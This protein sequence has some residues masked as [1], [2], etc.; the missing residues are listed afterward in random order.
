MSFAKLGL[1]AELLAE[2]HRQ[3]YSKPTP[4]QYQV[5]PAILKGQDILATAETGTGKTASFCLPIIQLLSATTINHPRL[6]RGLILVPTRELALQIQNDLQPYILSIGI[7]SAVIIGGMNIHAQLKKLHRG[8]DI[9]IATPGRLLELISTAMIELSALK[10]VVIDEA[11]RLLDLGFTPSVN[12][13]IQQLPNQRQTLLFSATFPKSIQLLAE[14]I[15]QNPL[16]IRLNENHKIATQ[17]EQLVYPIKAEY[18]HELLAYW[19]QHYRWSQVLVFVRTK[20]IAERLMKQLIAQGIRSATLHSDKN[21]TERVTVLNWFIAGRITALIATDIAARGLDIEQLAQVVN[22]DLPIIAEDYIHR[23]GRTGRAGYSG[24]AW[25]LV[26]PEQIEQLI[27]IEKLLK[28]QIP[29][30]VNTGYESVSLTP[31]IK[32]KTVSKPNSKRLE[33]YNNRHHF[34]AKRGAKSR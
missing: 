6:I 27:A 26:C 23:I 19:I 7:N 2:I 9:I 30:I 13:I 31:Q 14:K 1:S 4:I 28:Q 34:S 10:Y 29:R 17:I 15:L 32:N 25:S 16:I 20:Q 3:G 24:L 21:Q 8:I 18:K 22:Y 11:D 33:E 12:Q 5:I